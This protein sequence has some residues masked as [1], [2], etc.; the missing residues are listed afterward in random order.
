MCRYHSVVEIV[1]LRFTAKTLI[2]EHLASL[3]LQRIIVRLLDRLHDADHLPRY[4]RYD[5]DRLRH[6]LAG[7][8]AADMCAI[9]HPQTTISRCTTIVVQRF[10]DRR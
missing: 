4:R 6:P 8:D 10:W 1:D 3:R 7:L 5:R 9:E 2:H